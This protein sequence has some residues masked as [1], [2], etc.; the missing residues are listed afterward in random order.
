MKIQGAKK[1]HYDSGPNMTPLVDIVMVILIF[2][3]LAGSFNQMEHYLVSDV[4]LQ[5]KGI[6]AP[7]P[8]GTVF[9]PNFT[10]NVSEQGPMFIVKAGNFAS[11]KDTDPRRACD[12]LTDQLK[13]QYRSF[14]DAG[15][16]MDDVK[17]IIYP[18]Q[19]VTLDGLVPVFEAGQNAGFTKVGFGINA[20]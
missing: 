4:P 17:I 5:A 9:P 3:M 14:K 13:A 12:R 15:V 11:V 7:P 20:K 18:A 6:G 2:L 10:I 16:K 8:A 19:N 1:I